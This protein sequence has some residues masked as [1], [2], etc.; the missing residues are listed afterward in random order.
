MHSCYNNYPSLEHPKPISERVRELMSKVK[1]EL[2]IDLSA[3]EKN[4]LNS[5]P[6][7]LSFWYLGPG[8]FRFTSTGVWQGE[9][10]IFP[11]ED[12]SETNKYNCI[13]EYA[14]YGEDTMHVYFLTSVDSNA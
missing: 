9:R 4:L 13:L 1:Q 8:Q 12:R 7:E 5:N 14:Y 6:N 11:T 3:I 10:L 2:N